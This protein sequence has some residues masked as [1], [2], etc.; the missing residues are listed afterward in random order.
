MKERFLLIFQD[1]RGNYALAL[2][3]AALL[4]INPLSHLLKN[5]AHIG[6]TYWFGYF[7]WL[8]L[9]IISFRLYHQYSIGGIISLFVLM[10]NMIMP[11]L[12]GDPLDAVYELH[13]A[14]MVWIAFFSTFCMRYS[15]LSQSDLV[16]LY[17]II[18]II[19]FV[20]CLY[21]MTVQSAEFISILRGVDKDNNSWNYVSF[22]SQRN[23][24]GQY[25]F[26]STISSLYL[27]NLTKK[28]IWLL[29]IFMFGLQ[30]VM[31]N[32]R[33]ALICYFFTI[34]MCYYC[35]SS[36]KVVLFTSFLFFLLFVFIMI[37]G[38]DGLLQA[39]SHED[40]TEGMD[41]GAVRVVMWLRCLEYL[42]DNAALLW[43]FGAGSV[44]NFLTPLFGFGSSHS[45]Y[46][47]ALFCGGVIYLF[48]VSIPLLLSL[49]TILGNTD[50]IYRNVH[51]GA[52]CAFLLYGFMEA[53]MA[54]FAS[55]F[56]SVTSTL[57]MIMI[58]LN[59]QGSSKEILVLNKNFDD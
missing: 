8:L 21:A 34:L 31:I 1:G 24:Y 44:S 51:I 16:F 49:K 39:F 36:H 52:M 25:C 13:V 19:G 54:P 57:M 35:K 3:L 9:L 59:Y 55:N 33:A 18:S 38:F 10:I 48:I 41:S 26:L 37:G 28:K 4:I 12:L 46:V 27:L 42:K 14:I 50:I 7:C 45:F 58:P 11:I 56:F 22:F 15:S 23:I 30:I 2:I 43:G 32:S 40:K 29:L 20:A 17:K 47:D 5:T 6:N 53:G